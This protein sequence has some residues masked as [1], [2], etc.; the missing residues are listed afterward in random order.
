MGACCTRVRNQVDHLPSEL[1]AVAKNCCC[2]G[3][4]RP[5]THV[6]S[7]GGVVWLHCK[8]RSCFSWWVIPV[9]V[10]VAAVLLWANRRSFVGAPWSI[11]MSAW[12]RIPAGTRRHCKVLPISC[13][14]RRPL[15][16]SSRMHGDLVTTSSSYPLSAVY[17]AGSFCPMVLRAALPPWQ[18]SSLCSRRPLCVLPPV[19]IRS[20]SHPPASFCSPT[21]V[22]HVSSHDNSQF[23]YTECVSEACLA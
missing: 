23:S 19:S 7:V 8:S 17:Q 16:S 1:R 14:T 9:P 15:A 12:V 22:C 18:P 2:S 5:P 4:P 21:I 11:S 20:S 6:F 13:S 3:A 10:R